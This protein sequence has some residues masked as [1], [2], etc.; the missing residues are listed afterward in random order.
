MFE[1]KVNQVI[2]SYA[3][4]TNF[5]IQMIQTL[6]LFDITEVIVE[7]SKFCDIGL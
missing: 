6:R 2:E 1:L 7:I 3:T 4:N 5:L